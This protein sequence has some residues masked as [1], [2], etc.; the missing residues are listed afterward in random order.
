M[1][2]KK[3]IKA[4]KIQGA[5]DKGITYSSY[6]AEAKKIIRDMY[7]SSSEAGKIMLQ[8]LEETKT[9]AEISNTLVWGRKNLL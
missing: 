9:I 5:N 7:G 8:K 3:E 1:L 2:T 4:R 6:K